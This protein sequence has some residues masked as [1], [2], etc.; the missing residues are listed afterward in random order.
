MKKKR[1][2]AMV[3]IFVLMALVSAP[4]FAEEDYSM[5]EEDSYDMDP[6][7]PAEGAN[8][9]NNQSDTYESETDSSSQ[10]QEQPNDALGEDIDSQT[11]DTD[12]SEGELYTEDSISV[13]LSVTWYD[14][15][16][17]LETRPDYLAVNLYESGIGEYG[18]SIE[19]NGSNWHSVDAAILSPE[20]NWAYIFE[21][22]DKYD[23]SDMEAKYM[24]ILSDEGGKIEAY[25][26]IQTE[27]MQDEAYFI[28]ATATYEELQPQNM[29]LFARIAWLDRDNED[30]VRPDTVSFEL[31]ANDQQISSATAS[32]DNSAE[33]VENKK[34]STTITAIDPKESI[35]VASNA[36]EYGYCLGNEDF[37]EWSVCF[38]NFPTADDAGLPINYRIKLEEIEGYDT[39][40]VYDQA[41]GYD[42]PGAFF[43]AIPAP[44][45]GSTEE[46][47][48][49][50]YTNPT[51][52]PEPSAFP[53]NAVKPTTVPDQNTEP[54]IT[55]GPESGGI[56]ETASIKGK[57]IWD[58]Q[59]NVDGLRPAEVC[60]A[61][62]SSK[63]NQNKIVSSD[64][65]WTY[66]FTDLPGDQN[67][68]IIGQLF[69]G[70]ELN[71]ADNNLIYTHVPA[72]TPTNVPAD[73]GSSGTTSPS[74]QT[75]LNPT[76]NTEMQII[77]GRVVWDDQNNKDGLRPTSVTVKLLSDGVQTKSTSVSA[78]NNWIFS[79]GSVPKFNS[80]GAKITY[81]IDEDTISGYTKTV[82]G[83]T[84]VNTHLST[85]NVTTAGVNG[86]SSS[87]GQISPETM[88][89]SG[90]VT[91]VDNNNSDNLRPNYVIVRLL[92]DG[93]E[94]RVTTVTSVNGWVYSFA[95]IPKYGSSGAEIAY[96]VEEDTI[97]GYTHT[98]NGFNITNTRSTLSGGGAGMQSQGQNT[99]LS[100]SPQANAQ[101][102]GSLKEAVQTGDRS[103]VG[104]FVFLMIAAVCGLGGA[105]FYNKKKNR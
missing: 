63:I 27:S 50:N 5:W 82:N 33:E 20:N 1:V 96:S 59:D 74:T 67:Y 105:I 94:A 45:S 93:R 101:K 13:H 65:D 80:V 22:M 100:Y 87:A 56:P 78:S 71:T 25:S 40:L 32:S 70:Y 47:D 21:D 23:P 28:N 58:D 55:S 52:A 60:I 81:T 72:A 73:T 48:P 44:A 103:P 37:E 53:E 41:Y 16:N 86:Q 102:D 18:D 89:I 14:E 11:D 26:L 3:L 95:G 51:T 34:E 36:A 76:T 92:A 35:I 85:S 62:R 38:G 97:N 15:D 4:S 9:D 30:N 79:F 7:I 57:I 19:I 75:T 46:P 12:N 6:G 77:T 10:D 90:T 98:I 61:V 39:K 99:A 24:A 66:S 8:F 2:F 83:Y 64:T 29:S 31:Y 17:V 104:V 68:E 42:Y 54:E 49:S 84:I 91:W 43:A 69:D 88:N